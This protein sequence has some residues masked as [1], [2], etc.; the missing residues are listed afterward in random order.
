[1]C[2]S[3]IF[4]HIFMYIVDTQK[5]LQWLLLTSQSWD[6]HAWKNCYC[7]QFPDKLQ[8]LQKYFP[9]SIS[10]ILQFFSNFSI[11][12]PILPRLGHSPT[13]VGIPMYSLTYFCPS[14]LNLKLKSLQHYSHFQPREATWPCSH[15]QF[16]CLVSWFFLHLFT[17][18]AFLYLVS[19]PL[20]ACDLGS[21]SK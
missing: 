5:N 20:N 14:T 16:S 15:S 13:W 3:L 9:F 21:G 10:H 17:V 7:F 11:F 4:K 12:F 6:V 1:M 19:Y 8:K 18:K 2:V